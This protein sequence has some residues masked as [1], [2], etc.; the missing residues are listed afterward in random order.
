MFSLLPRLV[1]RAGQAKKGSITAFYS[2]LVEGDDENEP[3]AD[4]V[5]G[6][7]DGHVWLSRK[8][9]ARGHYPAVDVLSSISRLMNDVA[10]EEHKAAAQVIRRLL[11]SYAEHEDLISIGAYRRGA[12]R[13]VDAAVEMRD[14]IEELFRQ[15]VDHKLPWDQLVGQLIALGAQCQTK[16]KGAAPA[17]A[18]Q[19]AASA[20]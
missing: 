18:P 7:L 3:V 8:I 9:A 13:A 20:A 16:L 6:L 4:T 10:S 12:N 19:L 2:V 15:R 5:R 14:A 1:E 11:A 17:N